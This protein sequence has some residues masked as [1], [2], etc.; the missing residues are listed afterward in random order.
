MHEHVVIEKRGVAPN[1]RSVNRRVRIT[2]VRISDRLSTVPFCSY[3]KCYS[4]T[5]VSLQ[6]CYTQNKSSTTEDA[7]FDVTSD[8][9]VPTYKLR[10]PA[11]IMVC[12][13][14]TIGNDDKNLGAY[15][16]STLQTTASLQVCILVQMHNKVS[17]TSR[18]PVL[19]I[20][21]QS[22]CLCK[23]NTTYCSF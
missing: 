16:S 23:Q 15:D 22:Q 4:K 12:Y 17:F 21:L 10:P 3:F 18:A 14:C 11:N 1:A 9:A 13:L 19:I 2:K 20:P 5:A 7:L 6:L 8:K